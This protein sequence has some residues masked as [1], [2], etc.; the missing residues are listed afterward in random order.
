MRI[1]KFHMWIEWFLAKC[2][3]LR[4][5]KKCPCCFKL[6]APMCSIGQLCISHKSKR[7]SFRLNQLSF[8][9]FHGSFQ[10]KMLTNML[11]HYTFDTKKL[12][13]WEL[14]ARNWKNIKFRQMHENHRILR[15]NIR[16]CQFWLFSWSFVLKRTEKFKNA[17]RF[18]HLRANNL[19]LRAGNSRRKKVVELWT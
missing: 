18:K 17:S 6:E 16:S 5:L 12:T 8:E 13:I 7:G 10:S 14:P 3:E 15:Y 4:F 1:M 19:E 9:P 11:K 2:M